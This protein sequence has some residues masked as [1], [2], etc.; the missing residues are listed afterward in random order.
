MISLRLAYK[1]LVGAGLRTWLNVIILS[2]SFVVIIWFKGMLDGWD[3]QAKTDMIQWETGGGQYWSEN[4]DPYDPF[5]LSE[6]HSPLDPEQLKKIQRK[7]LCPVLITQA[8]VFPEGRIQSVLLKGIDHK[9]EILNIPTAQLDTS[10]YGIPALVGSGMAA[11]NHLKTGDLLTLRWRDAEG[12]FDAG[13]LFIAG[14]FNTNVPSVDIGQIWISLDNLQ[15][16]MGL[17]GEATLLVKKTGIED[18]STYEGWEFKDNQ[19][20]LKNIDDIIKSKSA[21]SSIFYF[22]L[23]LLAMLAIFDTQVLSIFRRQKEIGTLIALGMT[24]KQV[25]GLFTVEGAMHSLLAALVGALYGL[26]V[27]LYQARKGISMPMEGS[28][29]GL[30][31]ADKIYPIYGLGLIGGTLLIVVL[32][33]TIVS[34]LPARKIT[35]M[36]P[37]E[38]IKGK[39]Q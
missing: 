3:R 15:K 20:L 26:P 22:I 23:L 10:V 25:V 18:T 5:S 28:D 4:Y 7:E 21:G 19:F 37:T 24:R 32:T 17:P 29:Y 13:E 16:M 35:K 33:T 9:Q 38:A 12:T 11:N 31:M 30:T 2:F 6:S 14:V 8:S 27:F 39:I 1:N 36:N 34:Y